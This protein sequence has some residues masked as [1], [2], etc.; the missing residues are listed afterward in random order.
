VG[1]GL[2]LALSAASMLWAGS[3]ESAWSAA[4]RLG[5]YCV[6]FTI[7]LLAVRGRRVGRALMLILGS[8]ALLSSFFLCA[9]FLLGGGE[10]A[11]VLRR[12][13]AP[14]GY[15]NG[16][17]GLLAM[18]IWPWLALSETAGK[19]TIRAAALTA[20]ALIAGTLVLTQSRAVIPAT[21]LSALLV[22][23]C[24]PERFRRAVNLVVVAAAIAGTL[25]WTL[26]V[27]SSGPS[28]GTLRAA[29]GAI[30]VA[31]L[32][33]G[34]VRFGLATVGARIRAPA[35]RRLSV[36]L[37]AVAAVGVAAAAVAGEP[38]LARQYRAFTALRVHPNASVRFVDAGGYRYDLWRVA[39]KEFRRHPL[40]GVGA[41]NYDVE[42]YR[43]RKNPEYVL[44]PHSLELQIASELGVAGLAALLLFCGAVLFAAF[45]RRG[46]LASEDRLI[47]VA[48]AGVFVSWLI[49]TSVDWLYDIPGLAGMAIAAAAL[50]VAP[51][52][53]PNGIRRGRPIARV[54]GVALVAILAASVARQYIASRYART[55]S[56]QVAHSARS[57][58][59]TLQRA[60]Q[61]DPYSVNTLFT[62]A[63]AYARLDD[64]ADARATLELASSRE[65]YNYV[66]HALLGDLALRRGASGMAV[67]EYRS[68]LQLN[69]RD[70]QLVQAELR[71][72]AAR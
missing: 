11:F 15:V 10:G 5:L 7:V 44:E 29:A 63:S 21:I 12:L 34:A 33:A 56:S 4:N 52:G 24:A 51:G 26:A 70:P 17:A 71:A 54:L 67:S 18:G 41:G 43:L 8:A 20:A 42:Y 2:L 61:L 9:E 58:I 27:Y 14:I 13:S 37:L 3:R 69:P 48:A 49:A 16:T 40:V 66:P 46:T 62:L 55:G 1:L 72:E 57:A 25:P 31:A 23:A 60:A 22:L 32:G 64:Y 30:L 36:A 50:L 45:K 59:G 38:W 53:R 47:K 28:H 68:A 39:V 35:I 65:P 6:I 19:R